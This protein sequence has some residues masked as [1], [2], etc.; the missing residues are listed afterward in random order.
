MADQ[1]YHEKVQS[2]LTILLFTLL[3]L[4]FSALFAWRVTVVGFRVFPIVCLVLALFFFSY[5]LNY[6]TLR[7]TITEEAVL[8]KFGLIRW[9]IRLEN[10]QTCKMD[11]SPNLIKYGGAGVH[12]A[13]VKGDYLAYYNFLEYPR[14]RIT[15]HHKQGLVQG[16]VFTTRQPEQVME[17][18]GSRIAAQ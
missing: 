7:I 12:F 15:F 13:F 5:V 17:I 10:I 3:A 18:I 11:D 4:V 1:I 14:I 9:R 2:P 8:L 6:Q 16:V